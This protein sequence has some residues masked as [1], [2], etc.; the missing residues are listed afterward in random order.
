M[1]RWGGRSRRGRSKVTEELF[2]DGAGDVW[3]TELD[4]TL[5]IEERGGLERDGKAAKS[6]MLRRV[7]EK[8]NARWVRLVVSRFRLPSLAVQDLTAMTALLDD[9]VPP[10]WD[11]EEGTSQH[12]LK[13]AD[14]M[15][16]VDTPLFLA[17][18][19]KVQLAAIGIDPF[20]LAESRSDAYVTAVEAYRAKFEPANAAP[21]SEYH[22]LALAQMI[23]DTALAEGAARK[24]YTD[25]IAVEALNAELSER[26]AARVAAMKKV[27]T[28]GANLCEVMFSDLF[29]SFQQAGISDEGIVFDDEV[30]EALEANLETLGKTSR[31]LSACAAGRALLQHWA[32]AA[33]KHD[34]HFF[35]HVVMPMGSPTKRFFK[36]FRW[37]SKS[38]A[39][40]ITQ[41]IAYRTRLRRKPLEDDLIER[42]A[43]PLAKLAGR[44]QVKDF[45]ITHIKT[46]TAKA[47]WLETKFHNQKGKVLDAEV[48]VLGRKEAAWIAEWVDAGQVED[49]GVGAKLTSGKFLAGVLLDTI[50]LAF[51]L[52]ALRD[53]AGG[54]DELAAIAD[55][56]VGATNLVANVAEQYIK[57]AGLGSDTVLRATAG[58]YVVRA[59]TSA[60]Y[61]AK[62]ADAAID[63]F[64]EGRTGTAIAMTA[65]FA[66]ELA[67]AGAYCWSAIYV[68]S[69]AGPAVAAIAGLIAAGGYIA[70]TL[71]T[72]DEFK[73]FL[74]NCEWGSDK[75]GDADDKPLWS[76]GSISTWRGDYLLQQ[77]L[78]IKILAKFEVRWQSHGIPAAGI[79]IRLGL[80]TSESTLEVT[81]L[82]KFPS[83]K[84]IT[85]N[86]KFRSGKN[87]PTDLEKGFQVRPDKTVDSLLGLPPT[88]GARITFRLR[89]E[90]EPQVII[91][92]LRVDGVDQPDRKYSSLRPP[93][94]DKT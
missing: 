64:K 90:D 5:P 18:G 52:E 83:G 48:P 13:S 78:L 38:I 26:D 72:E 34:L 77:R 35:N 24:L 82:A 25:S 33:D 59:I 57:D 30:G 73:V 71:L 81:W 22:K 87:L 86:R 12:L 14:G 17:D 63:A 28:T 58:L 50:N 94:T 85:E 10:L 60:Y 93:P 65:A 67:A 16:L 76:P 43:I 4:P 56:G 84:T 42:F 32:E 23:T 8:G 9:R 46:G 40:V 20:E 3:H 36:A 41:S 7:D 11:W 19:G 74:E 39:S 68:G 15:S 92:P 29:L 69:T 80:T 55:F 47:R 6:L 88:L 1:Q 53:A 45:E 75:Y 66:G 54:H 31:L 62:N 44:P 70:A 27:E 2:V 89:A 37:G 61:V 51:S 91:F 49:F 21:G 79:R